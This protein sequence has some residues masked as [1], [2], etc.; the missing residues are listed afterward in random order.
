MRFLLF[1]LF[2]LP[3]SALN[4]QN[5]KLALTENW[6]FSPKDENQWL[7]AKVPGNVLTDLYENKKI[8]HPFDGN[9]ELNLQWISE[10]HWIYQTTFNLT[11]EK[12]KH[13]NTD[14]VFDGLD[15]Y[16]K[17]YVNNQLILETNNAFRSWKSDIKLLLK[18]QNILRIEFLPTEEIEWQKKSEIPYELPEGNRIFTRKAQ[19]QYGWDWGPKFNVTGIW[20]KVYLEF[21]DSAKIEDV[22][23]HQLRL[24]EDRADLNAEIEILNSKKENQTVEVYLNDELITNKKVNSNSEKE[25][26]PISIENPKLWWTHNLGEPFLYTFKFRLKDEKG[27]I[28]DEKTIKKGL[29]T[30]E[31]VN[32]KDDWGESFYFKLNGI[33]IYMKGANYIP[34]NSFQNWVKDSDYE[35]LLQDVVDSNMNMLRVW[36]GGAY[37]EDIFYDLCDEKGILVW[38]DFMFACA[39][40]PGDTAFLE[41]VRQEAIEN[42]KRLRNHSSIALWCGNNENSEGWHR[43]GWQDGRSESEKAEIWGNYQKLFNGILPDLVEDLTDSPYWETSPKFGRGDERYISEGNAHDWWI[44]HDGHP[45]ENLEKNTP[46][47]MSEFGFQS[48]PS[49][50][51][52]RFINEGKSTSISSK[53]FQSHQKHARGFE[54]IQ[55]YME[56]DFPIPSN[57]EDYVYM[58]QVL[59]AYGMGKGLEAQRRNKPYTMGSLYWQLNDCWPVVSWSGIDFFG[60]W[61]A[62]QYQVKH[63]FQDVLVSFER[64]ENK[65]NVFIVNDLMEKLNGDLHIEIIDFEGIVLDEIIQSISVHSNESK[66]F[67]NLDL[68]KFESVKH[69]IVIRATFKDSSNLYYVVKPKE[70]DLKNEEINVQLEKV[71]KGYLI[72]LKSKT[73]Q[74]NVMLYSD[75]PGKFSKNFIDLLP[76][77]TLEIH[78]KTNNKK[79]KAGNLKKKSVNDFIPRKKV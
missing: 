35:I 79:F 30:I 68:S 60:N 50:E 74:K 59:Q 36:G 70:L 34:Q 51:A 4:A 69:E 52:I 77:E 6:T 64:K 61:K 73:L 56:R 66:S 54:I 63:S 26:L 48:F 16:A 21:W 41:N 57:E 32:E 27:I 14:L 11:S 37:E 76:K 29:R 22:Y 10:K 45:F 38:Q 62:L 31:L 20:R 7:P 44:W 3:I 65:L 2:F 55:T 42:I 18:S 19:F 17:V 23:I 33:P 43:W 15:T 5:Y 71:E 1:I 67:F 46:R 53:E 39:M 72:R 47:F 9:N 8:P 12:L 58:S 25:I 78:F 40:Y 28:I 24:T 75:I 13:K 49:F